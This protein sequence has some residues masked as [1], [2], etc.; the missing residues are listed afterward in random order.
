MTSAREMFEE[1][2]YEREKNDIEIVYNSSLLYTKTI[3]DISKKRVAIQRNGSCT[4]ILSAKQLNAI[5]VQLKELG[6]NE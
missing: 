3:F 1:L 2:G 5:F 6:W 4:T